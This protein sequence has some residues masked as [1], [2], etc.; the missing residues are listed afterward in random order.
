MTTSHQSQD[1]QVLNHLLLGLPITSI[2][3]INKYGVTRCAAI[4][5]R[6]NKKGWKGFIIAKSIEIVKGYRVFH[7]TEYRIG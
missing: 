3:A 5:H 1:E 7:C 2:D 4:I 6:L